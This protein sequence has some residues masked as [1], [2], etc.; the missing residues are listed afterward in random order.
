MPGDRS[1]NRTRIDIGEA[2][3]LGKLSRD[4]AFSGGSRAINGNDPMKRLPI[5]R[6]KYNADQL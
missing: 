6:H 4:T 5:R 2:E 3:S 1:I